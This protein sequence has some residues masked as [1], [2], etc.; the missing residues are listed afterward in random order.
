MEYIHYNPVAAGLCTSAEEY[1][2]S[3][4]KFYETGEDDPIV[5]GFGIL[6]NWMA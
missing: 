4:A 1:R 5:I 3:S 6:T 2:Y